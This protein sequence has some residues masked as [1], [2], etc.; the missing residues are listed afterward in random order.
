[1]IS[2]MLKFYMEYFTTVLCKVC[3]STERWSTKELTACRNGLQS[4]SQKR[5]SR[6]TVHLLQQ[7]FRAGVIVDSLMPVLL[8]KSH[9]LCTVTKQLLGPWV[10]K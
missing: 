7:E 8:D 1:M 3:N 5:N 4:G 10:F 9:R 6:F 2:I